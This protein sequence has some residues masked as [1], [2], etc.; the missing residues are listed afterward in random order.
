MLQ[1]KSILII[2]ISALLT[3]SCAGTKSNQIDHKSERSFLD[4]WKTPHFKEAALVP[5]RLWVELGKETKIEEP[6]NILDGTEK[7]FRVLNRATVSGNWSQP[8]IILSF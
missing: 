7:L 5:F 4:W 8:F 3:V 1:L 6:N 2:L